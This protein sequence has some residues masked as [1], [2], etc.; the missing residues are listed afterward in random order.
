V[1]KETFKQLDK[2][3]KITTRA[4]DG[5]YIAQKGIVCTISGNAQAILKGERTALNFLGRLS[6]IATTTHKFVKKV[7]AY[8]VKILD[9]RKTT[10]GLR[11]LEKY[12]V[13][14]GGG[15]NHRF[16]LFDQVLIKD[17]H[18]KIL[19]L[20][21]KN[22]AISRVVKIA[23]Q[24]FQNDKTVE[25]EIKNLKE[26][27]SALKVFPDIIMLDNMNYSQIKKAVRLRDD[28]NPQVKLEASG[29]INLKNINQFAMCGV[30]FISLGALTHSAN[31][32][33]FSLIVQKK[34]RRS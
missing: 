18:I 29:N 19:K 2:N 28:L 33:D 16:G 22:C 10:P 20:G 21:S 5:D 27:K 4:K 30:D 15:Y 24:A 1:L 3:I 6:G 23:K 9:T 14:M 32:I 8:K 12:A 13:R 17:N 11:T 26:L 34:L 31:N 25:V 7:S